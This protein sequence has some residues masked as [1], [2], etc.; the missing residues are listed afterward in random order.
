MPILTIRTPLFNP[1]A[2]KRKKG[3]TTVP[4]Y[5]LDQIKFGGVSE[6]VYGL[7]VRQNSS[8]VGDFQGL[9]SQ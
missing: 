2:L 6:A 5:G 1:S 4:S 9:F 7:K 8:Q 3:V